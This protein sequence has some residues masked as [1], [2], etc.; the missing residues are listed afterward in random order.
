LVAP[1]V[2]KTLLGFEGCA[3]YLQNS[4]W[5]VT[6]TPVRRGLAR[7][8]RAKAAEK[9]GLDPARKIILVMGGSQGAHGLNEVTLKML[10]LL[11]AAEREAWQF[12]HL[13]GQA[14]VQMVETNYRRQRLTAV[15]RD[16]SMEMDHFYS[17][18]DLV[19]ARS[20]AASLTE[21]SHYGLPSILVPYPAAANDHQTFNARIFV[22]AGA[23]FLFRESG[24]EPEELHALLVRLFNDNN[25]LAAM[26][27]AAHALA[28]DAAAARVAEEVETCQ[29]S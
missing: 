7:I 3:H 27:A 1:R 23:A 15:V 26:A 5:V 28:G 6:G 11:G 24:V 13:A 18:A 10:P 14:D 16:F 22:E 17:M 8:D 19:I 21:I 29:P 9:Y 25:E 12:I 20:G 2:N 4:H